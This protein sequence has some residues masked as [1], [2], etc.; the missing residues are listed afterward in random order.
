MPGCTKKF[1]Q[2]ITS[3]MKKLKSTAVTSMQTVTKNN[4]L[5]GCSGFFKPPIGDVSRSI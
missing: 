2:Q 5:V 1:Q 3:D 4:C